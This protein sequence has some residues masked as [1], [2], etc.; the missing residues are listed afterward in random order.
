MRKMKLISLLLAICVV[1]SNF[2]VFADPAN[3]TYGT[4]NVACISDLAPTTVVRLLVGKGDKLYIS[5]EDAEAVSGFESNATDV[6]EKGV[7]PSEVSFIRSLDDLYKCSDIVLYDSTLWVPLNETM[8]RLNTNIS[9][10]DGVLTFDGAAASAREMYNVIQSSVF[11]SA[12][13]KQG[14]SVVDN[15]GINEKDLIINTIGVTFV[16]AF[17]NWSLPGR[18]WGVLT[19]IVSAGKYT[20]STQ[21]YEEII[22][23]MLEINPD[24]SSVGEIM[25]S[26]P[27]GQLNKIKKSIDGLN[28]VTEGLTLWLASEYDDVDVTQLD[29]FEDIALYLDNMSHSNLASDAHGVTKRIKEYM[30]PLG[31][32]IKEKTGWSVKGLDIDSQFKL[33]LSAGKMANA[34]AASANVVLNTFYFDGKFDADVSY[35]KEVEAC[36]EN[37]HE[38]FYGNKYIQFLKRD[39]GMVLSETLKNKAK[40]GVLSNVTALEME[41]GTLLARTATRLAVGKDQYAEMKATID[42]VNREVPMINLQTLAQDQ[43]TRNWGRFFAGDR[44]AAV[45]AKYSAM[46]YTGVFI[47][48]CKKAKEA[49]IMTAADSENRITA[50]KEVYTL[51]AAIDDVEISRELKRTSISKADLTQDTSNLSHTHN[52]GSWY[53][54]TTL[55]ELHD[56]PT[57]FFDTLYRECSICQFEEHLDDTFIVRYDTTDGLNTVEWILDEIKDSVRNTGFYSEG[58]LTIPS[59]TCI[60]EDYFPAELYFNGGYDGW[61]YWRPVVCAPSTIPAFVKS[62]CISGEYDPNFGFNFDLYGLRGTGVK[63]S[64]G[65]ADGMSMGFY[66]GNDCVYEYVYLGSPGYN[67]ERERYEYG[68]LYY[69]P[70]GI[71]PP[72]TVGLAGWVFENYD[73]KET[74][75]VLPDGLIFVEDGA[76][77][78]SNITSITIPTSVE[79]IWEGA[80]ENC[81]NLSRINYKGTVSQWQDIL[82]SYRIGNCAIYCAD[83][84]INN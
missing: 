8:C 9:V 76:F 42:F 34:T 60:I 36:A 74:D 55:D 19:G 16:D 53:I 59:I 83:G 26:D 41:F 24:W 82:G 40:N 52:F 44:N 10:L 17:L 2:I 48:A 5:M 27:Q 70:D 56:K 45:N 67:E 51:L 15:F 65:Y 84:V 25:Q 31:T 18:G 61:C 6:S 54:K 32:A 49:G 46:F 64:I 79:E 29:N 66:D 1:A 77:S 22:N 75:V 35:C 62:I 73:F 21:F 39:A 50:A 30:D 38:Y 47:Q 13:L 58:E 12:S 3:E 63:V 43:F 20:Y 68:I 23:G 7:T 37:L 33:L 28:T 4:I 80:F 11:G 57:G 78:G 14:F 71:I 72:G 81:T 69:S